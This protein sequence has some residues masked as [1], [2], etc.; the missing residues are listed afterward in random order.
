MPTVGIIHS[1]SKDNQDQEKQIATLILHLEGEGHVHGQDG[2]SIDGPHWAHDDPAK[3]R[4]YAEATF[5]GAGGVGVRLAAGVEL[6]F[7]DAASA[8][9]KWRAAAAVLSDPGL[10]PLD[11]VDLSI[12]SRPAVGGAGHSPPP[13]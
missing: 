11:Y 10:G 2:F 9:A 3:L 13:L 12:P 8:A 5:H 7:G 4:R 6:R 1:G